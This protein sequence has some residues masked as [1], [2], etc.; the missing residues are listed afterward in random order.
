MV[1][2]WA[3][4][5]TRE[6]LVRYAGASGDFN[7]IHYDDERARE[8]G[9]P[10]VI[11]HGMLNMGLAARYLKSAAPPGA[12]FERYAVRFRSMVQPGQTVT[13]SGEVKSVDYGSSGAQALIDVTVGVAGAEAA[14]TGQAVLSWPAGGEE[15]PGTR[16]GTHR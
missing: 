6:Q 3:H 2:P 8:F 4:T 1:G 10:G 12:R 9:L 13:I 11:A 16:W 5:I 14:V 15:S 7:P